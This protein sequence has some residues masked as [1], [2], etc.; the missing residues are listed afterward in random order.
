M[1][2][3]RLASDRGYQAISVHPLTG[4]L[5]AEIKGVDFSKPVPDQVKDEIRRA[6][7]EHLVVFFADQDLA[8]AQHVALS[9]I[10]GEHQPIPHLTSVDGYP[11]L[12]I[13]RKAAEDES[14][15]VIGENW[16]ADS[17]YLEIPPGG[18]CMR[19]VVIPEVGGDT[20]FANMYQ[21]FDTLSPTLKS[22]L[23]GLRA[24]HSATK[25]F[26]SQARQDTL[27]A[28]K[29]MDV[30]AGDR[31]TTH[32]VVCRHAA[33]GREFLF[34]NPVYTRRFDGMSEDESRGLLE[35]LYLHTA[36]P[37]FHCRVR[38]RPNQLLVW[39]NRACQHRAVPDYIGQARYMER[40]TFA[41][42]R[43]S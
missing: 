19:A 43:P 7:A 2:V 34:V 1:A 24:V 26:G 35:Y 39:D 12:Q 20:L 9:L 3:A 42:N 15:Y 30:S 31:E 14:A 17:T 8:A 38:W 33:T 4:A 6:F 41:G 21:V 36:R 16:H 40:T 29:S 11:E 37:Q 5:G 13:I 27:R 18:V 25:I 22:L 23:R 28:V 10:F 32:P